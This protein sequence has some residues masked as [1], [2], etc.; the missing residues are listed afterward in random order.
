MIFPPLRGSALLQKYRG[1]RRDGD[2]NCRNRLFH[3]STAA[4]SRKYPFCELKK[5][6][7]DKITRQRIRGF[8]A[9]AGRPVKLFTRLL[10]EQD[11]PN[12]DRVSSARVRGVST[13]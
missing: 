3:S 10:E 6:F 12:A 1:A 4:S 2:R 13:V 9:K 7:F 11:I 8:N 5:R